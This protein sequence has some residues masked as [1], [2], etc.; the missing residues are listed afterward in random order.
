M[1]IWVIERGVCFWRYEVILRDIG[2]KSADAIKALSGR[3]FV[4]CSL[5]LVL[6]FGWRGMGL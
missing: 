4:G 5:R 1:R 3:G 6:G 2:L